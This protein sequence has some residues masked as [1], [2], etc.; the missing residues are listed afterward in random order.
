M[1]H[2]CQRCSFLTSSL[3]PLPSR[4]PTTIFLTIFSPAAAAGGAKPVVD[5][6][7]TLPYHCL[8]LIPTACPRT[9][10]PDSPERQTAPC[11]TDA[12][13]SGF[14]YYP[15]QQP[16]LRASRETPSP[17][18]PQQRR[19]ELAFARSL[20]HFYITPSEILTLRKVVINI[21]STAAPS[22]FGA[23]SNMAIS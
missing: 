22:A 2:L 10:N 20:A 23:P 21:A 3:T 6:S 9:C 14:I 7:P 18:I 11:S 15:E 13:K 1:G 16:V 5:V 19:G 12:V 8:G 17:G 4:S